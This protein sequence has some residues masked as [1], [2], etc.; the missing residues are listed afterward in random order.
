MRYRC[1]GRHLVIDA[2]RMVLDMRRPETDEKLLHHSDR[3]AQYT[4]DDFRGLLLKNG[5]ECSMSA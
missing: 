2:L 4:S 1:I 3:G 5:I